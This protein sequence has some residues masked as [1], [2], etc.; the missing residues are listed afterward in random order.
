MEFKETWTLL[1]KK[2]K[3][4]VGGEVITGEI[5][6]YSN[7][8]SFVWLVKDGD[9]YGDVYHLVNIDSIE[10]LEEVKVVKTVDSHTRNVEVKVVK[11][12]LFKQLKW[13]DEL[14]VKIAVWEYEKKDGSF[15]YD[16]YVTATNEENEIVYDVAVDTYT[17]KSKAVSRR[18][19]VAKVLANFNTEE[20]KEIIHGTN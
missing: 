10:V 16:V 9:T 13:N 6:D 3:M 11:N 5:I 8:D 18:K 2:V 7:D 14:E 4:V 1:Y 15:E 19:A 12:E 20:V 17:N